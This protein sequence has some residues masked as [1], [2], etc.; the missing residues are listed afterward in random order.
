[1]LLLTSLRGLPADRVG[2]PMPPPAIVKEI[3]PQT[4]WEL[5]R[6]PFCK[7]S[8]AADRVG[9]RLR[10]FCCKRSRAADRVGATW[11]PFL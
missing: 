3:A 4:V 8:R 7:R 5:G 9:A 2:A 1:M 6:A 10:P 11:R